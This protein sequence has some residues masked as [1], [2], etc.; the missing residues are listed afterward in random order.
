M[1]DKPHI[2]MYVITEENGYSAYAEYKD[3]HIYTDGNDMEDLKYNIVESV[4]LGMEEYGY[5]Y[6]I[7][8]IELKFVDE[9][10]D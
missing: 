1:D 6:T 7:E 10:P 8:E 3:A 2:M 5:E 9:F 4:N